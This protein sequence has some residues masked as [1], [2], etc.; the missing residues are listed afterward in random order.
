M[1]SVSR[2]HSAEC[3][4]DEW[5]TGRNLEGGGSGLIKVLNRKLVEGFKENH[6]KLQSGQLVTH[7]RFEL[8]TS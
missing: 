8:C 6:E 4:T 1:L 5:S 7:L 2:L 3:R